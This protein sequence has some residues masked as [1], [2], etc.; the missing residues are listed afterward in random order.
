[1]KDETTERLRDEYQH[2]AYPEDIRERKELRQYT[3]LFDQYSPVIKPDAE[4]AEEED[5]DEL[6]EMNKIEE[7][8]K[9]NAEYGIIP[10]FLKPKPLTEEDS[11]KH[12]PK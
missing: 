5:D 7:V 2:N 3:E 1:M 11:L 9:R 12:R 6:D 4:I 10:D 8:D